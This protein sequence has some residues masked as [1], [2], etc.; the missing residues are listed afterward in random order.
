[1]KDWTPNDLFRD[2]DTGQYFDG[3]HTYY[4]PMTK[5]QFIQSYSAPDYMKNNV[6]LFLDG[7]QHR[8]AVPCEC[9][10]DICKGWAMMPAI[11]QKGGS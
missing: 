3:Q 4:Y 10:E 11:A 8:V 2:G 7:V 5:E 9:G 1:M 6:G